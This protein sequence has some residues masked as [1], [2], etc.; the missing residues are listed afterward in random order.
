M[1]VAEKTTSAVTNSQSVPMSY[2]WTLT[3]YQEQGYLW[4]KWETSSPFRAQKGQIA[5]YKDKTFPSDPQHDRK[6]WSWDNEHGAGS[7]WNTGL[8]YGSDW[9]CAWIAQRSPDGPYTYAVKLITKV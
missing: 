4:L 9:H 7:G 6:E 5:V 2:T 3:A 1:S 8:P